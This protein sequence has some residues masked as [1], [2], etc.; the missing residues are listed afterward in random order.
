MG[1]LGTP[2]DRTMGYPL[3]LFSKLFEGTDTKKNPKSL[4]SI[5]FHNKNGL[6][7]RGPARPDK[8]GWDSL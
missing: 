5:G 4:K 7:Y 1:Y 8:T 6:S 3:A 2:S